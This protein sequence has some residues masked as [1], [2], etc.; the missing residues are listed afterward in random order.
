MI[1]LTIAALAVLG[2]GLVLALGFRIVEPE[3]ETPGDGTE[4]AT[5]LPRHVVNGQVGYAALHEAPE[6]LRRHVAFLM[7]H[8]P[9]STPDRY[10][11]RND[12][13][14]YYINAYNALVLHFVVDAWPIASV[15][16]VHGWIEPKA[17]FG[18]FYALH[19]RLDGSYINLYDLENA[20]IRDE[21]RR[22][23]DPRRDRVRFRRRARPCAPSPSTPRRLDAELDAA[24]RELC[25]EHRHVRGRPRGTTGH[26]ERYLRLAFPT[27]SSATRSASV[28]AGTVFALH[29]ALPRRRR[30]RARARGG[31]PH[32][33]RE[34]RLE[35]QR[36]RADRLTVAV[37]RLRLCTRMTHRLLIC[38]A[39]ALTLIAC[40][41]EIVMDGS[42]EDTGVGVR[43]RAP[44]AARR[45]TRN[46][47]P[48]SD[49]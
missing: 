13:L 25:N 39:G 32:R 15:Q 48:T 35:R 18:F 45:S 14:A 29:R 1:A 9:R 4:L 11:T 6:P 10:P 46:R 30:H 49:A 5:I 19:A 23:A 3:T 21:F 7:T 26:L 24:M 33:A 12:R 20:I 17:G 38:A 34:L 2:V 28:R 43:A 42:I 36:I 41:G 47:T 44:T 8:G 22:R 31:L 37:G 40:D 16:D 27:T